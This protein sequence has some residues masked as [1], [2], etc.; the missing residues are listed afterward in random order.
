MLLKPLRRRFLAIFNC[1]SSILNSLVTRNEYVLTNIQ[2]HNFNFPVVRIDTEKELHL[3]NLNLSDYKKFM[4]GD[5]FFTRKYN[6]YLM[7]YDLSNTSSTMEIL[8]MN[9][10]F[11]PNATFILFSR[12][13]V[14]NQLAE[15]RKYF[16]QDAILMNIEKRQIRLFRPQ[17]KINLAT[18]QCT[19]YNFSFHEDAN[20][21]LIQKSED[22]SEI[23]VVL[24]E[25]PPY[26]ICLDCVQQGIEVDILNFLSGVLKFTINYTEIK[27]VS[28]PHKFL[29][30]EK[31][32][33]AVA[34]GVIFYNPFISHSFHY[35]QD[36]ISWFVPISDE[37]EKWKYIYMVFSTKLWILCVGLVILTINVWCAAFLLFRTKNFGEVYL[38]NAKN[39]LHTNLKVFLEQTHNFKAEFHFQNILFT[40]ILLLF[41]FINL[42]YKIKF[43]YFLLGINFEKDLSSFQEI[44]HRNLRVLMFEGMISFFDESPEI[45][46]YIDLMFQKCDK[47]PQCLDEVCF[48]KNAIVFRLKSNAEYFARFDRYYDRFGRWLLKKLSIYEVSWPRSLRFRVGHPLF[49][50][51]H[52]YLQ[53][54]KEFGFLDQIVSQYEV[55]V[56]EIIHP[57]KQPFGLNHL[58]AAFVLWIVGMLSSSLVFYLEKFKK[59]TNVIED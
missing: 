15:L 38:A 41:F 58:K 3:N 35:V 28:L 51:V 19:A 37:I 40:C 42:L 4:S 39:F 12:V 21:S 9:P 49:P 16:I 59:A 30:E 45:K 7:D 23:S 1:I 44:K 53:F 48:K 26:A 57:E 8:Q 22:S 43:S 10:S 13:F 14:E 18:E 50:K 55:K 5:F 33:D 56:R 2:N 25:Y 36:Y 17:A 32:F 31:S 47:S 34:G 11:N 27:R 6:I 29:I 46:E 54:M 20:N 52:R 24:L